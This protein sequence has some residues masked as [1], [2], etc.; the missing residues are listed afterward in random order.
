VPASTTASPQTN[1]VSVDSTTADPDPDNNTASDANVV[2]TSAD[3]ADLKTVTPDPV[4]AGES[5]FY[6][7]VVSNAGPSDAQAVSLVDNLPA[8][9]SNARYCVVS[10]VTTCDDELD[11]SPYTSGDSISLGLIPANESRT[12][13]IRVDVDSDVADGETLTNEAIVSSGTD[14]PDPDNNTSTADAAVVTRADLSVTKTDSPDPV[15]AGN[16]L[17]YTI[18]LTNNGPSDAQTVNLSDTLP[19]GTTFVSLGQGAGPAFTCTTPAVGAGGTVSCDRA[20]LVAGASQTF[21]LVVKVA[22]SAANGSTISNTASATT[23]TTDPTPGNDS[24][25]AETVVNTSAD[26]SV[27]KDATTQAS[28]GDNV[29]YTINAENLGPSD[30]AG[31]TVTDQL[32]AGTTFVSATTPDCTYDGGTHTVTCVSSG[33]AAGADVT[34]TIVVNLTYPF[35]TGAVDNTASITA[36]NTT[37][38]EPGNDSSTASTLVVARA[39]TSNSLMTNSAFELVDNLDPWTIT[40]FEVL[41]NPKYVITATNPGQFYYHQRTQAN[42]FPGLTTWRFRLDWPAEDFRPQ[43]TNGMPIHA[44]VKEATGPYAGKWRDWTPP[45][46]AIC[47][48]TGTTPDC[49]GSFGTISVPNVPQGAEV[50]VNAHLD[51]VHKGSTKTSTFL[52]TPVPYGPFKS[53]ISVIEQQTGAGIEVGASSSYTYLWGR[54][55]KVTM[56]YGRA[57]DAAGDPLEKVWLRISQNGNTAITRTDTNG[58]YVIYDD[59]TCTT[60]D[61]LYSCS[62]TWGTKITFANGTSP[63]LVEVLGNA[64]IINGGW[65]SVPTMPTGY[66]KVTVKDGAKNL[67]VDLTTPSHTVGT[68]RNSAYNRDWVFKP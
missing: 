45:K 19:A 12:V 27:T 59:Q 56:I 61:M 55:K 29:T 41:M 15:I 20:T 37:D 58:G 51:Y 4:V 18:S 40:D 60:S 13:K 33:L 34:W 68:S 43:T 44:Y 49:D 65:T 50:W 2:N 11:F 28:G 8:G 42:P 57:T 46:S 21:T 24:A 30:N 67:Q 23:T 3:L 53:M 16:N 22:S 5:L 38:P 52:K 1:S 63:S 35:P 26:L 66:S 39:I 9:T 54:G 47:W 32:P 64:L 31:F 62:G 25:T 36:N 7:I 6:T 17:T 14:D 10:L 48:S